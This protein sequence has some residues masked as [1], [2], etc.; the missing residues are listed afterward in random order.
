MRSHPNTPTTSANDAHALRDVDSVR[1]ADAGVPPARQRRGRVSAAVTAVLAV[2]ASVLVAVAPIPTPAQATG[3]SDNDWLGILNAYRAQS[4]LAPVVENPAWSAGARMH[5]CWMLMNG[6]AHDEPGGTPG[7]TVE[8]DQAGNSGNVAVTSFSTATARNHMELWLTGPFHAIG[9]LR[10]S[11][12]QTGFGMCASPP[13]PSFTNWKSAGTLDVVRGNNWGAPKPSTPVVFPGNG[14][15]I[16]LDR[17]I[18]ESP[19]P[20]SFCGWDGRTVGLPLI[21]LMPSGVNWANA[22]LSGPSGPVP[23]C[24][25]HAGNTSGVA[26]QILGGDN[27]VVVLPA[28]PLGTGTH[29]VSLT[30]SGGSVSWAF[31]VQRGAPPKPAPEPDP[32]DTSVLD[33]AGSFETV[34]PFRFAD[35]RTGLRLSRLAANRQVRVPIAG[36]AGLPDDMRAV[37]ANF[38]V[39]SPSGNGFLTASD[40][41]STSADVSTVNFL[42]GET[43]PNQALVPLSSDGELCLLSNRDTHV[44]IDVN[45]YVLPGGD[46][47][48]VAIAPKRI[49]DT[50]DG[51]KL[52][53]GQTLRVDLVSST[54]VPDDASAVALNITA[55]EPSKDGWL[56]AHPC[57][58]GNPEVSTLNPRFGVNRPNSAIVPLA[59]DGSICLTSNVDTHVVLDLTGWFAGEG[60]YEFTALVPIRLRDT[61]SSHADLNPAKNGQRLEAGKVMEVKVAGHRGVPDSAKA[62]V[63]NLTA[64]GADGLGWLRAVPCGASSGVSNLNLRGAPAVANG[65]LVELSSKGSIC[66]VT[67]RTTHVVVD[68]TGVWS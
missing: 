56:R 8:G 66:I 64:V 54:P 33:Q 30:T 20:R 41:T 49:K 17:F 59:E 15:T 53:Q 51:A 26:A 36:V 1:R 22:T 67:S 55:T 11:L 61:R 46:D 18:A 34:T 37:S 2:I 9:M 6:I 40:C 16:G 39:V 27:A 63:L 60:D 45:G 25:L 24:V 50:R 65:T 68:I 35:S 5:S 23:T 10:P 21:A 58:G 52:R 4:G 3:P 7:Y 43:S 31:N 47:L 14:A 13:N 12:T 19:D 48:F 57:D 29:S 38:T 32:L 28:A 62:A 44:V 42:A